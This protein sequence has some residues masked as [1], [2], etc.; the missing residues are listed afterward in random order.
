MREGR[1]ADR[2]NWMRGRKN[3]SEGRKSF[4]EGNPAREA[5][6]VL[7]HG[8]PGYAHIRSDLIRNVLLRIGHIRNIRLRIA[9]FRTAMSGYRTVPE[10]RAA[11]PGLT[12]GPVYM[13]PPPM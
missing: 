9:G 1:T 2:R 6:S 12:T 7:R 3:L 11:L 8:L 10:T 5:E 4:A 13:V